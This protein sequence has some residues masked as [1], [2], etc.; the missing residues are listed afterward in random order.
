MGKLKELFKRKRRVFEEEYEL[1]EELGA[2]ALRLVF[3]TFASLTVAL[4]GFATV[5]RGRKRGSKGPDVAIRMCDLD[6]AI[7]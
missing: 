4:G 5:W 6:V 3:L 7:K 1:I 2:G